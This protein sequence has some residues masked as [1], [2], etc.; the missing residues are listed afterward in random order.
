MLY[1][2]K[3]MHM[4]VLS[5]TSSDWHCKEIP[6]KSCVFIMAT[7]SIHE[8]NLSQASELG[9]T[10]FS[11]KNTLF[12]SFGCFESCNQLLFPLRFGH[13][14]ANSQICSPPLATEQNSVT[15]ICCGLILLSFILYSQNSSTFCLDFITHFFLSNCII[16]IT[17]KQ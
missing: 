2:I 6:M 11:L 9:N 14:Q 10:A 8:R 7:D 1:C 5:S 4:V 12:L 13:Q 3:V 15:Y 17:N 16:K